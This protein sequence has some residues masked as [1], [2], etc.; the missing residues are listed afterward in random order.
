[1]RKT[2]PPPRKRPRRRRGRMD[3][4]GRSL[5]ILIILFI[6]VDVALV[7]FAIRQCSSPVQDVGQSEIKQEDRILQIEVLNGCGVDGVADK[8]TRF[9]RSNDLDVVKTDNFETMPGEP[10]YNVQQTVVM[11]RQGNIENGIRI[12]G[13]LGLGPGRVLQEVNETYLIDATVIIGKDFRQLT[14]WK[15]ME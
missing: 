9:L 11:E 10:N 3:W 12:A 1:M 2:P 15:A 14:S 8:F 6:I 4:R 5:R 13:I 7:F